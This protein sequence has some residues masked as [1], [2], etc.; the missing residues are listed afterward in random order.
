MDKQNNHSLKAIKDGPTRIMVP[1]THGWVEGMGLR[2]EIT[3][4]GA[5]WILVR[6]QC[7][8]A[9]PMVARES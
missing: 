7:P 4:G 3:P 1:I 9:V 5:D 6:A 2:A 8:T